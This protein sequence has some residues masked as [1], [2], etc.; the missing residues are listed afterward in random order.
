MFIVR[1]MTYGAGLLLAPLATFSSGA[2]GAP[3]AFPVSAGGTDHEYEIVLAP[4]LDRA[5]AA[6]AAAATGGHLVSITSAAEQ[7]FIE[8]MLFASNSP[9]GGYWMGLERV[10]AGGEGVAGDFAWDTGEA[11]T[12]ENFASGEPNAYLNREDA[13][14]VYWSADLVDDVNARRG[15]WNDVAVTGY[16]DT[17]VADL[18]TA[19][20]VIERTEVGEHTPPA[21]IP[22]PPA[23]LAA[24]AAMA[25]AGLTARRRRRPVA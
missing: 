22:L 17:P 12:Y 10:G 9:T 25:L 11:L 2:A 13:A 5:A 6:E 24:P 15:G 14:Q 7:A 23:A 4:A 16:A 1:R 8:H 3:V 21:A 20:Y 19:G 18:V